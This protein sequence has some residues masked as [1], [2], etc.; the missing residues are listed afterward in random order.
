MAEFVTTAE[1]A[2]EKG[3]IHN[4]K[5]KDLVKA[6]RLKANENFIFAN[7]KALE[8]ELVANNRKF[9][10]QADV[11]DVACPVGSF[12]FDTDDKVLSIA[13]LNEDDEIEW[14]EV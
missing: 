10:Y 11:P 1:E 2:R 4:W 12:W 3:Y 13:V 7:M 9:F 8:D 6:E 5:P 14:R